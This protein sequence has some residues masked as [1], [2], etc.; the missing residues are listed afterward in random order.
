MQALAGYR[1]APAEF[2]E[3]KRRVHQVPKESLPGRKVAIETLADGMLQQGV[4]VSLVTLHARHH[5]VLER[6]REC[7]QSS[8]CRVP[9]PYPPHH[10][11]THT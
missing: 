9:P 7:H 3:A 8:G 11:V 10:M 1:Q 5:V 2:L 6:P 4:S